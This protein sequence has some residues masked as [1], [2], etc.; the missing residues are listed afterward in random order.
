MQQ[1]LPQ[2][3]YIKLNTYSSNSAVEYLNDYIENNNCKNMSVDISLMN[4][5][6]SCY[7]ASICSAKHYTKY[8]D[9]RILWKISSELVKE[10]NRDLSIGNEEYIV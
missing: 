7:V 10:L 2:I 8:P 3:N 9:G 6:D 1:L 4:V 5:I